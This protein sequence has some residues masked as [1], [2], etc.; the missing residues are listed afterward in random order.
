MRIA[1]T[2][3]CFVS[4]HLAAHQEKV[5]QRN[6]NFSEIIQ[7]ITF[8]RGHNKEPISNEFTHV[9]WV[10]DL[11]YRI[12]LDRSAPLAAVPPLATFPWS[13]LSCPA[14]SLLDL[15]PGVAGTL[16]SSTSMRAGGTSST[17]LTNSTCRNKHAKPSVDF[18]RQR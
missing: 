6:G 11:N 2:S 17:T 12:N 14:V 3:I 16:A 10:G 18:L 4:S 5:E 15:S 1:Q 8:G 7:N 13:L 9:I